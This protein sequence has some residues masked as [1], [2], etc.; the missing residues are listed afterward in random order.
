M[1][2]R[3]WRTGAAMGSAVIF[4]S[5]SIAGANPTQDEVFRS[6]NENVGS[7]VDFSKAVPYLLA[8]VAVIIMV[9]LYNNYRKRQ[10]FPRQ[11]NH[12]GKLTKELC[13]NINLR[14]AELKQLKLLA[15]EQEL[16]HPLTLI[17]CPSVLGK[18]IRSP[19]ARVDRAMV[20][21]IVQRLRQSLA[22]GEK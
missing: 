4:A 1:M 5:F 17:L 22:S 2:L 16:E 3:S 21:Q 14:S 10:T 13:R 11:L 19:S 20:K 9:A 18:A 6:I 12:A 7:T 8:T 15:E